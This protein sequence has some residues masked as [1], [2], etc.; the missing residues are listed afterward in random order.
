MQNFTRGQ[1]IKYRAA[2]KFHVGDMAG[3]LFEGQEVEFDGTVLRVEGSD[4]TIPALRGAVQN[5]WLVPADDVEEDSQGYVPQASDVRVRPAVVSDPRT[6]PERT[7][8]MTVSQEEREVGSLSAFQQRKEAATATQEGIRGVQAKVFEVDSH[9]N[10][11]V[12]SVPVTTGSSQ[13]NVGVDQIGTSTK[14]LKR[15]DISVVAEQETRVVS[16]GGFSS[17]TD[18]APVAGKDRVSDIEVKRIASVSQPQTQVAGPVEVDW[19]KGQFYA[20]LAARRFG[21][22]VTDG[23]FE[24]DEYMEFDG[25][26]LR[27]EGQE[28]TGPEAMKLRKAYEAG[29]INLY[30][31]PEP[32]APVAAEVPENAVALPNGEFWDLSPHWKTRGKVAIEKYKDSPEVLDAIIAA[33]TKGVANMIAKAR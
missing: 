27:Y 1:F 25:W 15:G 32:E 24:E 18:T 12:D 3:D 28:F 2:A 13:G 20:F 17:S 7:L 30:E 4:Y 9:G 11:G 31:V 10:V 14:P 23:Y 29:L 16:A 5:G 8:R 33:E 21:S 19:K 26:T 22:G 6:K